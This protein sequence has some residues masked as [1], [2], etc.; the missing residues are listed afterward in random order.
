MGIVFAVAVGQSNRP[1]PKDLTDS[2]D[3]QTPAKVSTL[4]TTEGAGDGAV[5][6]PQTGNVAENTVAALDQVSPDQVTAG[7]TAPEA[8]A[9]VSDVAPASA[10]D[11]AAADVDA[12][13]GLH[14]VPAETA[15]A[16][17][18]GSDD[19]QGAFN[20]EV[21]FTAYG[22]GVRRIATAN[23]TRFVSHDPN[24]PEDTPY[25]LVNVGADLPEGESPAFYPY[26]ARQLYINGTW[27]ALDSVIWTADA[28]TTDNGVESVTYRLPVVDGEGSPVVEIV[29]TWSLAPDSYDIQL[30]QRIVNQSGKSLKVALAQYAQGDVLLEPGNY[31]GDR[32]MFITGHFRPETPAKYG[33]YTDDGYFTRANLLSGKSSLWPNEDLKEGSRLA[34]VA[35]EN[36]YFSLITHAP[37]A[38][39]ATST[40][41]VT[42]LDGIFS[43]IAARKLGQS[44]TLNN[45]NADRLAIELISPIAELAPGSQRDLSLALFAGPRQKEV[46]AQHPFELLHFNKLIHYELSCSFCTWQWLAKG[47]LGYMKIIYMGLRD[48][49][50]AII[51]L[52]LSVRLILH[53]ITKRAQTNMLKMSKAM[54]KMQPQ[55]AKIK[56]KYKDDPTAMNRE[57]MKLYREAGVNPA[58]VLGC[59]P[60][61]LQTP[62]WIALYAM[63]YYAIELRH[64]PAFYG[65]FQ[66]LSGGAWHFLE[67]LSVS[68]NFIRFIPP[69]QPA[70]KLTW[71]PFIEPEFRSINVLPLAMAFV[72]FFQMKL[73]TPP[74]TNEQ[75]AQQQKIM[76]VMPF[77]FPVMLYSAPAGLTLYITASTLAG[78]VDS[79]IVRKHVR[80]QEEAGTLF[81]KKPAKPG[82]FRDRIAKRIQMAQ[83]MAAAQ[84]AAKQGGGGPGRKQVNSKSYKK[85]K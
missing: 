56:E 26:A 15:L 80:E 78:I 85:R 12:I 59:L 11:S 84:Q 29:R 22:A 9:S 61:L 65:I 27:L 33:V 1:D 67:D 17:V 14:V 82:G 44:A 60:M 79:W 43:T 3:A 50:V 47:L 10:V 30:Q 18:L 64:E 34:W 24:N 74:P 16:P 32:R 75:Q 68:D 4:N 73:T 77:I 57:T 51:L 58:N 38:D 40:A 71:L 46:L 37:I 42:E 39:S 45:T 20:V 31:L 25:E 13:E 23:Y 69:D 53:P 83:E 41:D 19:A 54:A 5:G 55:M 66:T 72:F 81:D 6:P 76:R 70:Y 7:Q 49:G 2:I 63:L 35:A 48:W 21:Q 28:K 52:V 8:S 62:I 36:R